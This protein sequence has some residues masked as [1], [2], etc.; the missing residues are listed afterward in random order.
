MT[1]VTRL[2]MIVVAF[3][4]P[5][6]SATA[7]VVTDWNVLAITATAVPP[8]SILQS[9]ALALTHAAMFDA[10]NA[11]D[12]RFPPLVVDAKAR[13]GAA[14]DAAGAAAAHGVLVRL[15][16]AQRPALDAAL[17][18]AL[19]RVTSEQAR[20]DGEA[21]GRFV[22]EQ[23]ATMRANDGS[24][25][26]VV[27][28]PTAGPGRWVPT[29]PLNLA[30]ILTQWGKVTPFIVPN[31]A[32]TP[33]DGPPALSSEAFARDFGEIKSVGARFSTTRTADQTAVA[34]FWTVQTLV[35]WNA[36]AR[37]AALARGNSVHENARVFALLNMAAADSQIATFA[38]KYRLAYWRPVTA[39]RNAASLNDRRLVADPA[40]EPLIGTPP[41]PD[42]PSAHTS[43]SGAAE[44]VLIAAFGDAVD[45]SVTH[46]PV[47]GVTRTYRAFSQMG[48][49]VE[50]ARVWGG[51]HFRTADVAGRD[52][53]R[54][55]GTTAT[56]LFPRAGAR[57]GR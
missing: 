32:A 57:S 54:R 36:A 19:G 20:A 37:A 55:I 51:I 14:M 8:N 49:E 56:Q 44:A 50:D 39:I 22:A 34:I 38:I 33:I 45:V 15:A 23:V 6:G 26:R 9:R 3:V 47:F 11:V 4:L 17:K 35:P 29:P 52:L 10:I 41:Q 53:G 7:D 13:P 46:P 1:L 21:V 30:P 27:F 25:A 12:R 42:Y 24:D 2:G 5:L 43:A 16:P 28:T 31:V 48:T 18:E 40:W